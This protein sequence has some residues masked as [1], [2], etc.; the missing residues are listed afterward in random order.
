MPEMNLVSPYS[1]GERLIIDG[2]PSLVVCV[3]Q[4]A[5]K[6]YYSDSEVSY[7]HNGEIRHAWIANWRLSPAPE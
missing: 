4:V 2:D 6:N 3:V 1:F 5:F 7:V